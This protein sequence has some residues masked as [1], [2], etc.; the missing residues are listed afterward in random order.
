MHFY[1][2]AWTPFPSLF[3][4]DNN[5]TNI[6][7]ATEKHWAAK[8]IGQRTIKLAR[9]FTCNRVSILYFYSFCYSH[10]GLHDRKQILEVTLDSMQCH[11]LYTV[12]AFLLMFVYSC[13]W[14]LK[15]YRTIKCCNYTV[16][17]TSKIIENIGS[18]IG[19]L[20]VNS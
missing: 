19:I 5:S 4:L 9:P 17:C 16:H 2:N 10:W 3:S 6:W 12:V 8:A 7:T 1:S 14:R 18:N 20:K 15:S 13:A 11:V